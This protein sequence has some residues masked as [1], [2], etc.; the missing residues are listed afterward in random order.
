M[1]N[2]KGWQYA[3]QHISRRPARVANSYDF[4]VF[5]A[6]SD[7]V[8]LSHLTSFL[9][10]VGIPE[11]W[12]KLTR[13]LLLYYRVVPHIPVLESTVN[14]MLLLC[15][16]WLIINWSESSHDAEWPEV[17]PRLWIRLYLF[18]LASRAVQ[19]AVPTSSRGWTL[20]IC[21]NGWGLSHVNPGLHGAVYVAYILVIVWSSQNARHLQICCVSWS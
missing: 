14:L 19:K 4:R 20:G 16:C 9:W 1:A 2:S 13:P 12:W 21:A 18:L 3:V 10:L 5:V 17:S 6:G 11:P 8:I 7:A 15:F